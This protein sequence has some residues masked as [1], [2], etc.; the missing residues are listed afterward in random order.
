MLMKKINPSPV[1]GTVYAST[2]TTDVAATLK[3]LDRSARLFVESASGYTR[4]G[5]AD[6]YR[7]LSAET[8]I[9]IV[10]A[11]SRVEKFASQA[12]SGA[13]DRSYAWGQVVSSSSG[14]GVQSSRSTSAGFTTESV[15]S[16]AELA[17]VDMEASGVPG[18]GVLPKNGGPV[19]VTADFEASWQSRSDSVKAEI[20][21]TQRY[22]G[23][24]D[25]RF[26]RVARRAS[27]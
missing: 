18:T 20:G 12:G 1:N 11:A 24:D 26:E 13:G 25:S 2:P 22:T 9:V 7:R 3:Q 23:H 4:I 19:V 8:P 14:S 27:R 10:N 6:A 17:L 21:G 5:A 15:K 16:L